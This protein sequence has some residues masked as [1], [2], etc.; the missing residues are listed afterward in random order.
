[1]D[2]SLV[3]EENA[4]AGNADLMTTIASH[5]LRLYRLQIMKEFVRLGEICEEV[6]SHGSVV[7]NARVVSSKLHQ[8]VQSGQTAL[9]P[10][11]CEFTF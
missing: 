10:E 11:Q 1:M 5:R 8:F 3:E 6:L 4:L 9:V 7:R 2:E